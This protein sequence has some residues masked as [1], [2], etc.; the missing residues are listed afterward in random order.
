VE[1]K[2]KKKKGGKQK[3]K[4]KKIALQDKSRRPTIQIIVI[5]KTES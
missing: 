5:T 4:K 1:A 2:D 3:K